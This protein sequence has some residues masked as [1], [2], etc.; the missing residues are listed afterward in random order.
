MA[1]HVFCSESEREKHE[2]PSLSFDRELFRRSGLRPE[3]VEK[4]SLVA[5]H[6]AK[7]ALRKKGVR[8]TAS[9]ADYTLSL[10]EEPENYPIFL[11][12]V[13]LLEKYSRKNV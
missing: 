6:G 12:L 2:Q 9:Q 7:K 3:D 4:R 10:L 5:T 11:Y 1:A 13:L 8:G